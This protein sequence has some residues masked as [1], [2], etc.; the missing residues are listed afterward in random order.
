MFDFEFCVFFVK[1]FIGVL[2][3]VVFR[4]GRWSY[5]MRLGL[6]SRIFMF[7]FKEG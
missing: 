4:L 1:G 6:R 3:G 2:F 7:Y 5:G